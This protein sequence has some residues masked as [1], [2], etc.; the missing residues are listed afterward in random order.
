MALK[1]IFVE[2][3]SGGMPSGGAPPARQRR[4]PELAEREIQRKEA[5]DEKLEGEVVQ[6][7]NGDVH[8]KLSVS[9]VSRENR[10]PA[11]VCNCT[12]FQQKESAIIQ[13]MRAAGQL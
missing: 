6:D 12:V 3:P 10:G 9:L 2:T 1:D 5:D 8:M 4:R 7:L 13:K 11:R